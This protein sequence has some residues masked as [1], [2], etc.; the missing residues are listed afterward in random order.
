MS[1]SVFISYSH[2]DDEYREQLETHLS[3]LKR[4][5]IIDVWHDRKI[6]PGK[7]WKNEIDKYI[8][9]SQVFLFLISADFISSDYCFE[10]EMQK[11]IQQHKANVSVIIPILIRPTD[12]DN[13]EISQF[14]GLPKDTTPISLWKNRDEAWLDVI[15][16][17]RSFIIEFEKAKSS[18]QSTEKL[19]NCL[20]HPDFDK[21]LK[22]TGIQFQHRHKEDISLTDLFVYPDIREISDEL[23]LFDNLISSKSLLQKVTHNCIIGDEQ[24]GKTALCKKYFMDL[25]ENELFPIFIKGKQVNSANLD[26]L[27]QKFA[28]EEYVFD[29]IDDVVNDKTVLIIDDFDK[30]RLNKKYRTRLIENATNRF[31]KVILTVSST[32]RI[33][34]FDSDYLKNFKIDELLTF[35]NARRLEI[36]QKWIILGQEETIDEEYFFKQTDLTKL[37][38]DSFVRKNIV[39]SKPIFILSIL[40]VLESFTPNNLELTSYGHCYEYLI[41]SLLKKINVNVKDIGT[42]VN[43]LAELSFFFFN[44][45]KQ[46]IPLQELDVFR[47]QYS[48]KYIS[49]DHQVI[50]SNLESCGIIIQSER[51]YGF[52]YRYI[53]YFYVAK[54]LSDHFTEEDTI[55]AIFTELVENLHREEYANI[56]IFLTH[57]TKN[58]DILDIIQLQMLEVLE[59]ETEATLYNDEL[60]FLSSFVQNIPKLIIQHKD[61]QTERLNNQNNIDAIEFATNG[62]DNTLEDELNDNETYKLI[63]KTFKSIEI[64]GQIIRNRHSSLTKAKLLEIADNSYGVGLRFLKYFIE[65]SDNF[66]SEVI[67]YIKDIFIKH[68]KASDDQVEKDARNTFLY[69]TYG[70]IYS[71][72]K[73]ISISLGST[74]AKEIYNAIEEKRN[75]PA[76]ILINVSIDLFFGKNLDVDDLEKKFNLLDGNIVAQRLFKESIIQHIYM[77]QAPYEIKQKIASKFNIPFQTQLLIDNTKESKIF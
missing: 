16:G 42:Y 53:Y 14:Q 5:N 68:P 21:W 72:L 2:K 3:L 41:V 36:I 25:F 43:Y 20:I 56:I 4:E 22:K 27:I 29:N 77:Y 17:L 74:E 34:L 6:I 75:T 73:K 52:N 59:K 19:K 9:T 44:L 31:D 18:I 15:K 40:Q 70:L 48:E 10:I 62:G 66:K 32:F 13:M 71:V 76:T 65:L 39:P 30:V 69:L 47:N 50:I 28:K 26:N 46:F 33:E 45:K 58:P 55:Q 35:G 8:E 37:Q 7:N 61:P 23:N 49:L 54:Y 11:A 38:I 57:H 1:V 51:G 64:I 12:W 60:K 63:N 24:I 67:E